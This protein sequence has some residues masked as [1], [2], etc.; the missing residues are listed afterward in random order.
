MSFIS[1]LQARRIGDGLNMEI[2]YSIEMK[3]Q[4]LIRLSFQDHIQ[5]SFG[6]L[7]KNHDL[8]NSLDEEQYLEGRFRS[9]KVKGLIYTIL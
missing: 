3:S 6:L 1:P 8:V 2:I 4:S 5:V 7:L 9:D